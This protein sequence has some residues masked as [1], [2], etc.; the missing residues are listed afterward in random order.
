MK[1]IVTFYTPQG[2]PCPVVVN[3]FPQKLIAS[4]GRGRTVKLKRQP[5]NAK[6]Q[7]P[8]RLIR[9]IR[10]GLYLSPDGHWVRN[11]ED[12]F[13]FP[14]LRSALATCKKM[15]GRG[16]EMILIFDRE[17]SRLRRLNS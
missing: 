2:H 7:P 8:H 3:N 6:L 16:V 1:F 9:Q 11:E 14:D 15:Q 4:G 10:T 13:D 17:A 5:M 12:A